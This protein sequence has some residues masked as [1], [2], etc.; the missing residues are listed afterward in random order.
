MIGR[1][2]VEKADPTVVHGSPKGN[3]LSPTG[4]YR[5][6][7]HCSCLGGFSPKIASPANQIPEGVSSTTGINRWPNLRPEFQGTGT[8][9]DV[10]AIYLDIPATFRYCIRVSMLHPDSDVTPRDVDGTRG[11]FDLIT[12]H[13]HIAARCLRHIWISHEW[14]SIPRSRISSPQQLLALHEFPEFIGSSHRGVV[15]TSWPLCQLD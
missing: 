9:H 1:S 10:P 15:L 12:T 6:E 5:K 2:I 4:K 13:F 14:I 3:K 11:D 7:L 8:N